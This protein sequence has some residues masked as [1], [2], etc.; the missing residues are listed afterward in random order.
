LQ[1]AIRRCPARLRK[2]PNAVIAVLR[3]T[4]P[5]EFLNR[6]DEIIVSSR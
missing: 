1:Q 6:I 3:E 5:A 4:L 2:S